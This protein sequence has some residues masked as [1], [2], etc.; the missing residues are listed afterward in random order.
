MGDSA[1]RKLLTIAM[2]L[3]AAV[4]VSPHVAHAQ[5]N[6]YRGGGMNRL[7]YPYANKP[8]VTPWLELFRFAPMELNYY[9]LIKP[10]LDQLDTNRN[11]TAA[12]RQ[13]DRDVDSMQ[14][15]TGGNQRGVRTGHASLHGNHSHFYSGISPAGGASTG[16]TGGRGM[17]RRSTMQGRAPGYGQALSGQFGANYSVRGAAN[18]ASGGAAGAGS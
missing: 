18:A 2:A 7:Q 8:A 3:V 14:G 6:G 5:G 17:P 13:L 1:M 15:L 11:T 12:I 9:N 4:A 10:Q 16:A